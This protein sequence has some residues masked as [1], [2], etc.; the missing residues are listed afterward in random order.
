MGMAASQSVLG[1]MSGR[2]AAQNLKI[3]TQFR[4]KLAQFFDHF[5]GKILSGGLPFK[6]FLGISA[7]G[8]QHKISQLQHNFGQN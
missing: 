7:K 5:E 3:A 8:A 6:A 4:T 2:G 1:N